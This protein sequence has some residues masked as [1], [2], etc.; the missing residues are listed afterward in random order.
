MD[1]FKLAYTVLGGL[2]IFFYGMKMLSEGLQA[3][4]S[5]WIRKAINTLTTNRFMAVLVGLGVTC[6]VQSSSITTV[7]V[8]GFVNAGL[9]DLSQ[10]IGVILG[11][12]IGTTITGWIISIKIGKYSLLLIGLS[13]FPLLFSRNERISQVGRVVFALGMVFLGLELM[14]GAFKPLR[15]NEEFLAMMQYF[16]AADLPSLLGTILIGCLLTFVVQSSSAM[17]GITIALA[18]SGSITFQTALALVMGE[19]I[20]TTITALLASIGANTNARRA[21]AAHAVFNLLGVLILTSVFWIYKDFIEMII[22]GVADFTDAEGQKPYVAAHIA[23]GHTVFNVAN[24][25]LFLP[26]MKYLELVV[27]KLVPDKAYKEQKKLEFFGDASTT[28][29]ALAIGL[30]RAELIKMAELVT[31]LFDITKTFLNSPQELTE[32]IQKIN[33]FEHITDKMHMEITVFMGKVM[34]S[35]MT[36]E[37]SN[38]VKAILRMAEEL[39]SIADYCQSIMKYAQRSF[40]QGFVFDQPTKDEIEA[41]SNKASELY[42]HVADR[43]VRYEHVNIDR[44]RPEWNEFN[45]LVEK[46]KETHVERV[47]EGKFLPV[48]SL[49]L[50]DIVVSFRRIKN[51]TVNLAEAYQGGKQLTPT[52]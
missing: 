51:H 18:S 41:L 42:Q 47:A 20:G 12:N 44:L 21:G 28:S 31:K 24:V 22:G 17:L 49:T 39:E 15:T 3:A 4:A 7:M 11:A 26:L 36:G 27:R 29:P 5:Q 32:L 48:A 40:R 10:A 2:G 25:I 37:E 1:W 9:M 35:Q 38:R 45:E 33:K 8:V 6:F 16:S 14:S 46:I 30:A 19:N 13:I 52:V 23:A 50:S 34:E 43:I